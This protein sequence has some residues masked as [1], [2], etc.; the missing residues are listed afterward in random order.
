VRAD[1]GGTRAEASGA[2]PA[3]HRAIPSRLDVAHQVATVV[4]PQDRASVDDAHDRALIED[5]EEGVILQDRENRVVTSN[6][7]ASRILGWTADLISGR[8]AREP[9]W[10][11]TR[12]DGSPLPIDEL[13]AVVALRTAKPQGAQ[14][15]R[16]QRPDASY[17][18]LSVTTRPVFDEGLSHP[19]SV[20]VSF[21]DI[22]QR[23]ENEARR[24]AT[25]AALR[26][27]ERDAERLR[28]ENERAVLVARLFEAERLESLGRLAR[29]IAHDFRNLLGVILNHSAVAANQ[30]SPSSAVAADVDR[31]R[32]AAERGVEVVNRLL[33]FNAQSPHAAETFDVREALDL[34]VGLVRGPLAP[35]TIRWDRAEPAGLVTIQR[36]QLEQAVL[37]L[38]LNARDAV[39]GAGC[40]TIEVTRT[41]EPSSPSGAWIRVSVHD[42]G[43]GMAPDVRARAFEPGFT[44]KPD[45]SGVGL[46]TVERE[47]RAA[48]GHVAL[49]SEPGHGTTVHIVLPAATPAAA[50]WGGPPAPR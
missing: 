31:I 20:V 11:V 13:P 34:V 29:G 43:V 36:A 24:R 45:G 8:S 16:V 50:A 12:E 46:A 41:S 48:G 47:V 10:P 15:L 35:A 19:T 6:P 2:H 44:T 49:E 27:R 18:W 3:R 25:E 14:V 30:L 7:A 38:L 40:I 23:R 28:T 37:N 39:A 4:L 5:L 1:H 9:N 33:T 17:V 26:A 22:T 32:L 21:V 42:D